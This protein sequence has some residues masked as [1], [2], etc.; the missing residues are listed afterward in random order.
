MLRPILTKLVE[1][2][3]LTRR[4]AAEAMAGIMDGAVDD[5][6][7][8]A[9]AVALR[10][11]GETVDEIA[12]CAEAMRK[13]AE[14][15]GPLGPAASRV[16]DTCGTG[17]DALG[18]INVSTL[19]ALVASGAGL[20]VAKHG[21]RSVSSRCGSTDLLETLGVPIDL[22]PAGSSA[23]LKA[24]GIAFL[25]A[26][27]F[28]P[29]LRHAAAA[30]RS[31]G[32]RTIFNLLG[33][34]CNPA[35]VKRQVV[36]VFGRERLQPLAEALRS[37][38]TR[39]ALL[40]H[41]SDGMDELTVTG[42]SWVVEVHEGAIRSRSIAPE[43]AGLRRWP[44]AALRG[45]GPERNAMRAIE[46]LEGRRGAARDVTLLNAAAALMVGGMAATLREGVAMAAESIDEGRA[47]AKL[48]QV[49]AFCRTVETER[50]AA[51]GDDAPVAGGRR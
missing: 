21:N 36:G 2:R 19:A 32:M 17:G 1:G 30:R 10:M 49:R 37:L 16:V 42:R 40:V 45:G 9:F 46:V 29:A 11:K 47:R 3:D 22:S 7:V 4:E 41:G 5:A 14:P 20:V 12:G 25:F 13:R 31:L 48:E 27:R 6:Q 28:H 51:D 34:L 50:P 44:P 18:T 8:A 39:R 24:T 15:F 38:G 43:Q 26:P 35:G 23:C 33:P